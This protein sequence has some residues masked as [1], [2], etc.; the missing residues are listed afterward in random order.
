MIQLVQ[1][2]DK[3]KFLSYKQKKDFQPF[4]KLSRSNKAQSI[5]T[6]KPIPRVIRSIRLKTESVSTGTPKKEIRSGS[7]S[8]TIRKAG[9]AQLGPRPSAPIATSSVESSNKVSGSATPTKV[10]TGGKKSGDSIEGN[11]DARS[12]ATSKAGS[13]SGKKSGAGT[14]ST[15][16][17]SLSNSNLQ[18]GL[19][20]A[21]NLPFLR[22]FVTEQGKILSRRLTRVT[23]RQQRE[24]TKAIKQARILGYLQFVNTK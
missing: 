19:I 10:A 7:V 21:Q 9:P 16:L 14:Q 15:S 18:R 1:S 11:R 20:S 22:R 2:S 17:A 5:S 3:P 13:A 6:E 4:P 23:A 24:I 12:R 8:F